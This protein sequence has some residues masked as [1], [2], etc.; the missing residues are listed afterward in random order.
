MEENK[1]FHFTAPLAT[2]E[3]LTQVQPIEWDEESIQT[4]L[5]LVKRDYSDLDAKAFIDRLAYKIGYFKLQWELNRKTKN[6]R[7]ETKEELKTIQKH[8]EKLRS[9]LMKIHP[10]TSDLLSLVHQQ[11]KPLNYDDAP[12]WN[13]NNEHG[14]LLGNSKSTDQHRVFQI[15]LGELTLIS[16]AVDKTEKLLESNAK[17]GRPNTDYRIP[18]VLVIVDDYEYYFG[19]R[20]TQTKKSE[21]TEESPFF[22]IIRLAILKA[23]GKYIKDVSN[24]VHK[25]LNLL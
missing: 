25:A 5:T 8:V 21:F 15:L 11:L 24:L 16:N 4:I 10:N 9:I 18:L 2:P 19:T 23:E 13:P 17:G 22:G 3:L 14:I 20:P 1:G 12:L 7:K 6:T